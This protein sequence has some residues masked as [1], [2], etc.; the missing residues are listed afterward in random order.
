MEKIHTSGHSPACFHRNVH[1]WAPF[2]ELHDKVGMTFV[3][4]A[5]MQ[6][7]GQYFH[8]QS[9]PESGTLPLSAFFQDLDH[10]GGSNNSGGFVLF[11]E[12]EFLA[13]GHEELGLASF[14][15]REQRTVL[16]VRRD[17][18]RRTGPGKVKRSPEGPRRA[19]RPRWREGFG[20]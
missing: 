10:G 2:D 5:A 18:G 1:R 15:Q 8:A 9:R 7:A 3:R 17:G 16:R 4:R 12:E 20:H 14:S 13:A 11:R 19:A 6:S